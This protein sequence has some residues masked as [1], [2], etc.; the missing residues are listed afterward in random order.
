MH[1]H[2]QHF[3][4]EVGEAV[5]QG[6]P[7]P[8]VLTQVR[9][10]MARLVARDDWLP[11]AFAQAHAEHYRQNLMHRDA[12]GRFSVVCFVWGPGQG[13]PIHDH[14]VWGVIGMLRG[15]EICTPYRLVDGKPERHGDEIA[16][17]PGDVGMVSPTIGDIHRVRNASA[18]HP[19]ISI[20]C[21]GGDIG[22]LERHTFTP[23]SREASRFVSGYTNQ[24]A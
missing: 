13:T 20:H 14:T 10:A 7:E 16:I 1:E 3:V 24:P 23:G 6:A 8:V 22:R 9:A 12:Q 2:F 18:T 5:S 11:E 4:A 21:Y 15:A 17:A 19:S